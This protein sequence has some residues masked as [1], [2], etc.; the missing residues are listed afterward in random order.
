MAKEQ[1][2]MESIYITLEKET[3]VSRVTF[4]QVSREWK[5]TLYGSSSPNCCAYCNHHKCAIT[6]RQMK[7][8]ECLK[9]AC[10][11]LVRNES[12]DVWKQRERRK[13]KRKERKMRLAELG[14][15]NELTVLG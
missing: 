11:H 6:V 1:K 2:R 3:C 7:K 5:E 9:K 15:R 13:A 12:H 4:E 14:G 10:K 8:K